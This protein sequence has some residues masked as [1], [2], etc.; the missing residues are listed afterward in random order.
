M[1]FF[2]KGLAKMIKKLVTPEDIKEFKKLFY[3]IKTLHRENNTILKYIVD[4]LGLVEK[5][6]KKW[7]QQKKQKKSITISE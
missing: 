3:D 5:E 1:S 2:E 7:Q 6:A 4:Q